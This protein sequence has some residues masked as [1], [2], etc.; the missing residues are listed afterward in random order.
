M[1]YDRG[2]PHCFSFKVPRLRGLRTLSQELIRERER[3]ENKNKKNFYVYTP[4][5]IIKKKK[6]PMAPT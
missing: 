1:C 5:K 4:N 6:S 2:E 3:E